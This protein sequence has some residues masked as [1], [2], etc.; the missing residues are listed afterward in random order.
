MKK[1]IVLLFAIIAIAGI[2]SCQ[3]T[4]SVTGTRML[5]FNFEKGKGYD[6]EMIVNM[7]QEVKGMTNQMDI[8]TYYSMDVKEDDGE[9]KTITS[10]FDRL[11]MKMGIAGMNIE[12]DTDKPMVGDV[13]STNPLGMINHLF[14]AIKG[15]Q[16][17]MKVNAEGKVMEV[18]G[19]KNMAQAIADSMGLGEKEKAGMMQK[20][21]KQF[22]E[23]STKEQFERFL[24]IFPNKE[25]KVGDSWQKTTT[26]RGPMGGK[27]NSVYTV[28]EIEGDMVTL[29][30]KTKISSDN[31]QTKMS[32][33]VTGTLIIDS[34]TGL[35]VN[36]DQKMN[37]TSTTGGTKV[38]IKAVSKI[39]GKAR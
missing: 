19:F 2:E 6:Y 24:Y 9:M 13:D 18:T 28:S 37:I 1:I 15:Q 14:G 23:E 16:F 7:D 32:G 27:Y 3:S 38:E 12:V 34:K 39:K 8:S 29:E 35:V 5:K 4:K 30:E 22:N 17:T 26:P 20:F 31:D 21:N 10:I 36:A 33:D 11:K 25:V